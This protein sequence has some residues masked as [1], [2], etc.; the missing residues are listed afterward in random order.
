L[1]TI[2]K[3]ISKFSTICPT[4]ILANFN[5]DM[6]QKQTSKATHLFQFMNV[7]KMKLQFQQ[8]TTIYGSQL[9]HIWS[10]NPCAQSISRTTKAF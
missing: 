10:N 4:I 2:Q 3:L 7:N 5:V 9:D 6:L 1:S 8:S